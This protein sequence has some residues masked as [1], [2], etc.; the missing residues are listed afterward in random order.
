MAEFSKLDKDLIA[1]QKHCLTNTETIDNNMDTVASKMR[2]VLTELHTISLENEKLRSDVK[3]A[4][5]NKS[6]DMPKLIS[7]IT[8]HK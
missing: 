7:I 1:V 2:D 5:K 4:S 3:I 6:I 8:T